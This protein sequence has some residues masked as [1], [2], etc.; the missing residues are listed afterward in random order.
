[1]FVHSDLDDA[2]LTANQFRLVGRVARRAGTDGW[3]FESAPNIAVGTKLGVETVRK[4]MRELRDLGVLEAEARRG[5]TWA[6]RINPKEKWRTIGSGAIGSGAIGSGAI[7]TLGNGA[8][9]YPP[10]SRGDEV[11]P[12][13]GNPRKVIP[14]S[15]GKPDEAE[16]IFQMY[17]RRVAKK[18]ALAVIAKAIRT[19]GLERIETATR[20]FATAWAGQ[21]DLQYCPHPATWFNQ[22]RYLEDPCTWNR[23]PDGHDRRK[24]EKELEQL[25]YLYDSDV[26]FNPTGPPDKV[27]R[28][29]DRRNQLRSLL[30]VKTPS[31]HDVNP[32]ECNG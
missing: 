27:R 14:L 16:R 9:G 31:A 26:G 29:I 25:E 3:C 21:S 7:A 22:E 2:G 13:E 10:I 5:K 1:M 17:P 4:V 6:L 15:S 28:I 32:E 8:G 12:S 19:H 23:E 11:Y 24:L 20:Q 30:E 18:K